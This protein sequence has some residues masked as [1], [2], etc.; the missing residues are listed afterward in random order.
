MIILF[1]KSTLFTFLFLLPLI[2]Q[3]L[4]LGL[5]VIIISIFLRGVVGM[6]F[7]SWFG[8][9]LFL[10]Y[11]GGLLVIFSYV[12]VLMPN[13]YFFSKNIFFYSLASFCLFLL[14]FFFRSLYFHIGDSYN[15][16][17]D[18]GQMLVSDYSALLYLFLSLILFFAL[19]VVVKV[20]HFH[21]GPLRPF[22]IFN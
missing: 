17:Q 15:I 10:I 14:I 12:L 5:L 7:V 16:F 1:L 2:V 8:F 21:G 20:C 19:L 6:I 11:V 18:S 22:S 4:R 9:L 13:R 3:P